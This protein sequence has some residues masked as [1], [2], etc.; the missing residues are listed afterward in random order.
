MRE[1]GHFIGGKEVAGASGRS[2]DVFNPNTGEVQAKVAFAAKSE[3]EKAIADAEAAQPAWAA[4]NPRRARAV[5]V[6][7]AGAEGVRQPRQAPFLRARQDRRRFQGRHPARARSGGVRLRHPAPAQGRVQRE[8]RARHRPVLD[9]P[10]ARGR[11]RHT[12]STSPAM[13]P[14]WKFAPALACGNAFILKPSSATRRCRC[15]SPS[16][17]SR[18]GFPPA[19]STSSTATRRRS[20]PAHRS[21]RQGDRLRRLLGHRRIHLFDRLRARQTRA[22]LRRR[23]EPHGGDAGRRHGPGGRRADR[24]GLRLRRR[25]AWRC[26][27]RCRSARRPRTSWSR[28]SSRAWRASRSG[29][30]AIRRPTTARWLP[31]RSSTEEELRRSRHQGRRQAQG[32]RPRLQ[33]A[34]LRERLLHGRLPV[35]RGDARHAHLQGEIFGPVLSVVRAKTYEEALKL[36]SSTTTATASPS[37]PATATP[38]ATSPA[39]SMSAWWA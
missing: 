5:Q 19:C 20:T 39:A 32:R 11:R 24:R 23:Q 9:P 33:A 12:P 16:C 38:R 6:P 28:S 2:G 26:R 22:V 37:S 25:A 31:R 36:P 15:A 1:I 14:M 21:A 30:R 8:R 4:T 3:V 18:P 17:S 13:I 35:R 27:W 34:G 7:R 10:A 29:R